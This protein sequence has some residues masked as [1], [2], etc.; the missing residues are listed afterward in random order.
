MLSSP[1]LPSM[2]TLSI[3]RKFSLRPSLKSESELNFNN[4]YRLPSTDSFLTQSLGHLHH[5]HKHDYPSNSS[6]SHSNISPDGPPSP[7]F[8]DLSQNHLSR[9]VGGLPVLNVTSPSPKSSR[10]RE[11]CDNKPEDVP[12]TSRASSPSFL[13]TS[14][15]SSPN[16]LTSSSRFSTGSVGWHS[17]QV[18]QSSTNY[19]KHEMA[20]SLESRKS[21][22]SLHGGSR[23]YLQRK[24]EGSVT[25]PLKRWPSVNPL[26]EVV[27]HL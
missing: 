24:C 11:S 13:T 27:Y 16:M 21:I 1:S 26:Q 14:R 4:Q 7:F 2:Q 15:A 23:R 22:R 12:L 9:S 8:P 20:R 17:I 25:N 5:L 6:L 18:G 3:A 10:S 19:V